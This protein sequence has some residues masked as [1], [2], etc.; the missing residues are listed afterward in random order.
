M[1]KAQ[2]VARECGEMAQPDDDVETGLDGAEIK[3]V[4][5]GDQTSMG[6]SG[7]G[8][9][10]PVSGTYFGLQKQ[11]RKRARAIRGAFT[12][13]SISCWLIYCQGWDLT[14]MTI[15]RNT[16]GMPSVMRCHPTEG[17]GEHTW[18]RHISLMVRDWTG[19]RIPLTSF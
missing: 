17:F 16:P 19:T 11:R 6:M 10:N 18:T 1:A 4:S 14:P 12:V 3:R 15:R 8:R 2:E 7:G 5:A 13:M 9:E